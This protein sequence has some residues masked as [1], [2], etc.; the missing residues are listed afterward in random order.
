MKHDPNK[1]LPFTRNALYGLKSKHKLAELLFIDVDALDRL[2]ETASTLYRKWEEE[3]KNGGF[4]EIEAPSDY[5][6]ERQK[7]ISELLQRIDAPDYLMSP[8]KGRSY[9]HNAAEHVG[10]RAFCLLDL[11]NFF[12]SCTEKRVFW[13]FREKMNCAKDVAGILAKITTL[14]GRLPQG[15]PC[16]PILAYFSYVDMWEEIHAVTKEAEYKLTIYVDDI[17]ISAQRLLG[18]HIWQIKMILFRFGHRYS[19]KKE[20]HLIDKA[21]D[22]TG[23]IVTNEAILLPNRQHQ[24]LSALKKNYRAETKSHQKQKLTRRL[25]G[26]EAQAKQILGHLQKVDKGFYT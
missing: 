6:K 2:A 22:V 12:P 15:S 25:R 18:K 16:S 17:T 14:N 13:F 21:A 7:R 11:E 5:L 10:S 1:K 20:R 8:V 9:V 4:R 24:K 26:R 3:K 19:A 23:V